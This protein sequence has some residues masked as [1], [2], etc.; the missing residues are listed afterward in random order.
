MNALDKVLHAGL[1]AG[2]EQK[3]KQMAAKSGVV[4]GEPFREGD[5]TI[6]TATRVVVRQDTLAARP[7]GAILIGPKGAVLRKFDQ[8][9]ARALTMAMVAA[10]VF[11]SAMLMNP[12]WKPD[13]NLLQQVREL[14]KTIREKPVREKISGDQ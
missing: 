14:I 13:T 12:P 4:F 10:I 8:P 5:T 1:P 6:I 3:I 2:L 11:W 7:V 9:A